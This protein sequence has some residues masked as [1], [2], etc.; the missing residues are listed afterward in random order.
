MGIILNDNIKINA[1]KPSESKYLT[2]G[3]T[4]YASVAAV[5]LALPIPVRYVGLTV[6]V[7]SGGTNIE[8]WYENGVAD[9]NLI[10]KKFAS[11][12]PIGNF[13]T[14]GSNVGFF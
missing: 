4:A 12:V 8:Y 11:A 10:Q 9:V 1:G 5:N 7:V 2:S 13:V 14:G 6:L 3:N